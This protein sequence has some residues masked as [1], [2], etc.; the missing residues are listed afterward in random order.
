MT[1]RERKAV[2]ILLTGLRELAD[3]YDQHW[4]SIPCPSVRRLVEDFEATVFSE[5][6]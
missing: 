2:T 3:Y 6:K 1:E 4:G 5:D